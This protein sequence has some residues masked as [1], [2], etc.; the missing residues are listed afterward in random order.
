MSHH[1]SH[2]TSTQEAACAAAH[3]TD[4]MMVIATAMLCA[5]ITAL[6]LP[7]PL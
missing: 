3:G 4:W 5:G 2:D 7:W 6:A 1:I